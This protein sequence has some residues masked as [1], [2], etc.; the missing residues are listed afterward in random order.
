[1]LALINCIQPASRINLR[2][3]ATMV[4]Q[5]NLLI[6]TAKI[7]P[8]AQRSLIALEEAGLKHERYESECLV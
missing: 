4:Q 5:P 6:Y 7:C 8:Y 3:I 1:M 2:R